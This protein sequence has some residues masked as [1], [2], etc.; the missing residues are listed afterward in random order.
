M[1]SK[2]FF[3]KEEI[4]QKNIASVKKA[5]KKIFQ[6]SAPSEPERQ[7]SLRGWGKGKG[8]ICGEGEGM[9]WYFVSQDI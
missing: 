5:K 7:Q 3:L 6:F 1:P 8:V 4:S 9:R 2:F